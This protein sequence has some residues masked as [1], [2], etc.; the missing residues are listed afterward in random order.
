LALINRP[1]TESLVGLRGPKRRTSSDV[2][3]G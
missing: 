1:A 3:S 2:P